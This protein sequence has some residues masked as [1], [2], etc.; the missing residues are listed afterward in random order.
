MEN[1]KRNRAIA[2]GFSCMDVYE[3]IGKYYP[4]VNGVDWGVHLQ[5]MGIPV[6]VLSVTGDDEYGKI[7]R[8]MLEKEQIDIS[9]LHQLKGN[10]CQMKMDLVNGVDRL[11]LEEVEG[12]M[13]EFALTE[14]D[15][16]YIKTFDYM[17][18]D[19]FGN[20]L[21]DLPELHASGIK[22]VMDFSTFSD[23]SEFNDEENYKYVDYAFL[24]YEQEDDYIIE[25]IKKIQSFGPKIVTATLGEN[26]SSSYD[27]ERYYRHGIVP[28]EVVN[29][30]GAGDSYI[31]GFA[32]GIMN[33]LDIPQCQELGAKLSSQIITKFEPY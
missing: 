20:I 27:G 1:Q 31:A 11:H 6:S 13:G 33:G 15:K 5:R 14:E 10:T 25:H 23:D 18:T 4:T 2:V 9:H 30:V 24:S 3:K 12:V 26:G 22:V 17:H 8:E 28:V 29:T 16:E 7:M 32:Y 19:L 21:K